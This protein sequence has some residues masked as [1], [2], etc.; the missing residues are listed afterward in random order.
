MPLLEDARNDDGRTTSTCSAVSYHDSPADSRAL[1][2][3]PRRDVSRR[4]STTR[5]QPSPGRYGVRGIPQT[6]FIDAD[7]VVR[8]RVFG[9]HVAG[10]PRRTARRNSS[11]R[12]AKTPTRSRSLL[13]A[14]AAGRGERARRPPTRRARRAR[15]VGNGC[16]RE[17]RAHASRRARRRAAAWRSP[18]SAR[19]QLV[20]RVRHAAEEQQHE[21]EGVG[22]GEVRLGAQRAGHQQADAGERDRAE[23]AAA[24]APATTPP[25]DVPAERDAGDDDQQRP[26]RPRTASTVAVFAASRPP[27]DSGVDPRRFSTP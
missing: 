9:D 8:D 20:E 2:R 18:A 1:R 5:R 12:A 22:G 6:F 25:G 24:R 13:P 21:E 11:L 17:H 19:G 16:G 15:P 10:R 3:P 27:R 4:C 26:A 14:E 23:R 7:G